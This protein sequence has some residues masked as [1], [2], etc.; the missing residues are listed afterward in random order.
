MGIPAPT[1]FTDLRKHLH[2]A[3]IDAAY[4]NH[5]LERYLDEPANMPQY[6]PLSDPLDEHR[7]WA[8]RQAI[9][10]FQQMIKAKPEEGN[11]D[12]PEGE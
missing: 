3:Q 1:S 6:G 7:A 8:Y 12:D 5:V 4:L 9:L 11:G 2:D 10:T